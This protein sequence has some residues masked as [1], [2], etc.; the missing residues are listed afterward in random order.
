VVRRHRRPDAADRV[1]SS[2]PD[3]ADTLSSLSVLAEAARESLVVPAPRGG[4]TA[5][6]R[7]NS[8]ALPAL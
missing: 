1:W 2:A 5:F 3:L 6:S 7:P 8:Y 4:A